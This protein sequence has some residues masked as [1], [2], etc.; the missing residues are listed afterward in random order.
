MD[1]L[2]KANIMRTMNTEK[3]ADLSLDQILEK[4]SVEKSSLSEAELQDLTDR[5]ARREEQYD[6]KRSGRPKKLEPKAGG[7]EAVTKLPNPGTDQTTP[8]ITATEL[9][10]A[11]KRCIDS[12]ECQL[13]MDM[14]SRL[15]DLDLGPIRER[16]ENLGAMKDQLAN[17]QEAIKNIAATPSGSPAVDLTEVQQNL[18]GL[19]EKVDG[20]SGLSDLGD[21]FDALSRRTESV[22]QDLEKLMERVTTELA[23]IRHQSLEADKQ[24]ADAL[25]RIV[26]QPV[27]EEEAAPAMEETPA[28]EEQ[29]EV[30]EEKPVEER[31]PTVE[32]RLEA[33]EDRMEKSMGSKEPQPAEET[34]EAGAAEEKPQKGGKII[35]FWD[36]YN[37]DEVK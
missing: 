7:T 37:L 35:E 32:E 16:L 27:Q 18:A 24:V 22:P 19:T 23:N 10:D 2:K 29:P 30:D 14:Q 6:K 25:N 8:P 4:Y 21:R 15:K 36:P 12:G 1:S 28:E 26:E 34:K 20:L 13:L 33:L 5:Y 9:D 3:N 11:I 31:S 17:L